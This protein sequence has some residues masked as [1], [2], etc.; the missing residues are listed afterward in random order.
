MDVTQDVVGRLQAALIESDTALDRLSLSAAVRRSASTLAPLASDET[1]ARVVDGLVGLGPIEELLRDDCV[2]DIFVNGP[3]DV[4]VDRG[5][6]LERAEVSFASKADIVAAVQRVVAPLG[7]RL[8]T[9]SPIVDAR[10]PD[11]SRLHAAIPPA[12]VDGPVLAVR[13][14]TGAFDNL[15]ALVEAGSVGTATAAVLL[16]AV[17]HRRNILVSGGTGA[18]KTTMLNVLSAQIPPHE[19]TVT[20]ED[21]AELRLHGHVV[22]LE[23]RPANAEGVGA[24]PL[25]MLVRAALR[26]RPDRIVIGEVRGPEA[27][28]LVNAMNTGHDGSMATVHANSP[29]DALDR[30]ETLALSGDRRVQPDSIRRQLRSAIHLIVHVERRDGR[31]R[32]AQVVEASSAGFEMATCSSL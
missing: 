21:A 6:Q 14:F 32:V 26:L 5:R 17:T 7:L 10:L 29:E 9:A 2:T 18:G 3:D 13:R 1:L 15:D 11:G 28:D 31:R 27:L 12:S 16:D 19:R 25:E 20:V 4:W 24:V 22:R 30:L 23:G 8:D